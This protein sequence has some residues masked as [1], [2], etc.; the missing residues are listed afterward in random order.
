MNLI[1]AYEKAVLDITDEFLKKYY[2]EPSTY[3]IADQIGGVIF[4]DDEFWR[5]NDILT[6]IKLN[7]DA[8]VLQEWYCG[9]LDA[10]EQNKTFPNLGNYIKYPELRTKDENLS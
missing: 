1:E 7:A 9:S 2:D 4:I 5:F 10:H 3:W 8:D 6:A